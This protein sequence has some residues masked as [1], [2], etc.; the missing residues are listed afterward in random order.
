[1]TS[2]TSQL[3]TDWYAL[4]DDPTIAAITLHYLN[5]DTGATLDVPASRTSGHIYHPD[6]NLTETPYLTGD[7]IP[8]TRTLFAR[9]TTRSVLY[10][11]HRL[12]GY[13]IDRRLGPNDATTDIRH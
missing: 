3:R 9:E 8:Y 12:T 6:G 1:M 7:N 10:D 4:H 11:N 5:D 2:G 13:T